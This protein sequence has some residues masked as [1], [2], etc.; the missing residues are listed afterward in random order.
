MGSKRS[1]LTIYMLFLTVIIMVV[2]SLCLGRY[3]LSVSQ[4]LQAIFNGGSTNE[5]G[6][7]VSNIVV[8][9]RLPRIIMAVLLGSA[10]SAAGSSYQGIFKNPMVS[11]SLLGVS[12]GAGFGAALGIILDMGGVAIQGMAFVFGLIA[13]AI[14]YLV[15]K[16]ISKKMDQTLSLVL[17]GIVVSSLFVSLLSLLKYVGDPY[18]DL[19]AITFWTLGSISGVSLND[20]LIIS[21]P[22]ILGISVLWAIKWK[23]NI[24]TLD[25]DE[26]MSLG[27]QTNKIRGIVILAATVITAAVVSVSGMIS[28]VGLVI[29]HISRMIV[30]PDYKRALPVSIALGAIFMLL[31]DNIS[32]ALFVAEVPLGILT[33]LLGTPFFIYLM[34]RGKKSW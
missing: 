18:N 21:I 3:P 8:N 33:S 31:L 7:F 2:I 5:S 14:V 15:S 34:M 26:A 10:L 22:V 19:P 20:I 30:G 4:V 24:M 16:L 11:P 28:W 25:E 29:P 1:N 32:R 6:A 9:V 12:A 27:V 17:T 13:V 23:M